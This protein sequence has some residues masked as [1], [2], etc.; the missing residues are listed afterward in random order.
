MFTLK[1]KHKETPLDTLV[2]DAAFK[3]KNEKLYKDKLSNTYLEVLLA[4]VEDK[5][6]NSLILHHSWSFLVSIPHPGH[7]Y[8]IS[9][10]EVKVRYNP[11]T[12]PWRVSVSIDIKN[13]PDGLYDFLQ[14]KPKLPKGKFNY[15][16]ISSW[17]DNETLTVEINYYTGSKAKRLLKKILKGLY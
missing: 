9:D 5:I 17:R 1:K 16:L 3:Y 13:S 8:F 11:E 14:R 2:V 10:V 6:V 15:S 4:L 7:D 12:V